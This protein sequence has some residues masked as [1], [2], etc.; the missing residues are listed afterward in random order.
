MQ[1]SADPE[2]AP[3]GS[4]GQYPIDGGATT[5]HRLLCSAKQDEATY[6]VA[7]PLA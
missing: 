2:A 4:L 7:L 5:L 1:L 6:G 3:N